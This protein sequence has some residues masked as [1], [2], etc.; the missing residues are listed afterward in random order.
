MGNIHYYRHE[1]RAEYA[2]VTF[3][4][5]KWISFHACCFPVDLASLTN[6]GNRATCM[7]SVVFFL[8]IIFPLPVSGNSLSLPQLGQ[9]GKPVL[10]SISLTN[11][12][13]KNSKKKNS[14]IP[15]TRGQIGEKLE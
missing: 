14:I 13:S 11:A 3:V 7:T 4:T 5:S 1:F 15:K 10:L 8:G 2:L 12:S 6:F 9:L